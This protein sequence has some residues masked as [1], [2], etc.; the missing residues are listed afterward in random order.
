MTLGISNPG[1]VNYAFSLQ[2]SLDTTL[3]DLQKL[4][5]EQ[6]EGKPA[7]SDQTV[8]DGWLTCVLLTFVVSLVF[9]NSWLCPCSSS[10]QARC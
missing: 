7:P 9:T 2:V 1:K 5:S 8:S 10:L 6:Y 3:A 4:I